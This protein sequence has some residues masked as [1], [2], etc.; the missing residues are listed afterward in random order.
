MVTFVF[1]FK[2]SAKPQLSCE[3]TKAY[4][5]GVECAVFFFFFR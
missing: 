3:N 2:I 4:L 5:F 1:C